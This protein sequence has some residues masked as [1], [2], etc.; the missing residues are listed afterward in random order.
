MGT[1]L[2]KFP[3]P[4]D[5]CNLIH[6]RHFQFFDL[7]SIQNKPTRKK[8]ARDHRLPLAGLPQTAGGEKTNQKTRP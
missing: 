2:K 6:A 3:Q 4:P 5:Y 8:L 1:N 7:G